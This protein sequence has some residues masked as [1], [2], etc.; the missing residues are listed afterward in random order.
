MKKISEI[1][2]NLKLNKRR[3]L[4]VASAADAEVLTA[5]RAGYDAGISDATL[6]GD[7]TA[8]R[9]I[10]EASEIDVSPFEI[11]RAA[12]EA[13]AADAAMGILAAGGADMV[14]K[15]LLPTPVFV[16]ALL[17]Q[18]HGLR[19]EDGVISALPFFEIPFLD[20][21][22]FITDPGF[23]PAPDLDTKVK[24]INNAVPIL[25]ALGIEKPNVAAVCASET[26]SP[27][28]PASV[29]ARKL[30][31]LNEAGLI[32]NCTVVGPISL[33]LAISETSAKHKGF[34][35]PAAGRADLLLAPNI[36]SA[37]VF[38]KTLTCFCDFKLAG[39]MTG[40]RTPVVMTS[41]ADS[42]ATKLNTIA[43]AAYLAGGA[44]GRR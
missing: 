32:E 44:A 11:V 29:D 35:H 16:K 12:G 39:L 33:D 42:P 8:I 5:V 9:R 3:V 21:L 41:R 34:D 1:F 23:I 2:D 14:M 10:A 19:R 15:G 24:M 36:E 28:I 26:V 6:V 31:E 25:R 18:R 7:E 40:A 20:R 22:L 38:Y 17:D 43:V 4:A 37:N 30:Q 13:E 27:K